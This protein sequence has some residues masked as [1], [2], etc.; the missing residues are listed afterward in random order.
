MVEHSPIDVVR[1]QH[2]G[3]LSDYL[4]VKPNQV[5]NTMKLWFGLLSE[6]GYDLVAT[7]AN[8][9]P[10]RRPTPADVPPAPPAPP[11]FTAI[12][13]AVE[14]GLFEVTTRRA[15]GERVSDQAEIRT[16]VASV[17]SCFASKE[18]ETEPSPRE[19]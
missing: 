4:G 12:Y 9:K 1:P 2:W 13:Q 8:R 19:R 11:A 16:I 7:G 17:M 10:P 5:R 3:E 18:A 15:H 14:T 6:L